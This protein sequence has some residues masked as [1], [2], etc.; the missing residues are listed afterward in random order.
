MVLHFVY[1]QFT[2][3]YFCVM[4]QLK[5]LHGS[6]NVY[7]PQTD[8]IKSNVTLTT[9]VQVMSCKKEK[10]EKRMLRRR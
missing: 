1:F 8:P 7:S 5:A 2:E 3:V 9:L 6:L 10:K 4:P